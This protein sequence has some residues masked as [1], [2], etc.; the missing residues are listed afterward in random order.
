M[1]MIKFPIK[2]WNYYKN[3]QIAGMIIVS[4]KGH[5]EDEWELRNNISLYKEGP[6]KL[7]CVPEEDISTLF[8]TDEADLD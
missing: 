5:Y 3:Y 7:V 8:G 2:L 6:N 1:P 4:K